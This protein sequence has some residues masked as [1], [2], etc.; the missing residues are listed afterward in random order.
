MEYRLIFA[1]K[2]NWMN[3]SSQI[4]VR[5]LMTVLMRVISL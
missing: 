2:K 4:S 5:Q 1:N 3:A